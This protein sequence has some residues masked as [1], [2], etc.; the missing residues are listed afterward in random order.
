MQI[1]PTLIIIFFAIFTQSLAGF[2]SGLVSMA[3][4][5]GV[6]GVRTAVPLVSL[7][8]GSLEFFLLIRYRAAFNPRAVGRLVVTSIF[9]IPIG[10]WALRQ[11]D[12]KWLLAV[13]GVVMAGYALYALLNFR[14]PRLEN[15]AWA[16]LAGFLAGLLSGA[17]SVGGPPAIIYGTCRGWKP[18]EFKTNLQGLFLIN[19]VL[20]VA[21]HAVA[22]N[23]TPQV[24]TGYLAALPVLALGILAGTSLD[25]W[26]DPLIF[27]KI[28][29][30]LL[31]IMG[32]RMLLSA[33][34][35]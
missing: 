2:G 18:A 34:L 5:P 4:L 24:W 21:S 28:V 35:S 23:L 26:L 11:L 8:T 29:L 20:A 7:V 6:L 14:L 1:L 31:V 33:V 3:F 12:E 13:L 30:I 9:A 17:Y 22:G 16:Y 27:R 32:L 10:V 25:R 15:P 19:D